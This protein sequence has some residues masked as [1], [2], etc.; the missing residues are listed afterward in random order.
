MTLLTGIGSI[1]ENEFVRMVGYIVP[2]VAAFVCLGYLWKVVATI[3]FPD[4]KKYFWAFIVFGLFIGI[5]GFWEQPAMP[6]IEGEL[7]LG[8]ESLFSV[9]IPLGYAVS[10]IAIAA[11]AFYAAYVSKGETRL[12]LAIIAVATLLAFIV[13]G[14]LQNMGYNALGDIFNFIWIVM[15]LVIAYWTEVKNLV[16]KVR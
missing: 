2:H 8:P 15:F 9:I 5:F 7:A 6:I 10:A 11:G 4:Y 3:N 12:K 13:S 14:T 1:Y 16:A